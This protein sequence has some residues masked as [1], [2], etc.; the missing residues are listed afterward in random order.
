MLASPTRLRFV[1]QFC[2][3]LA[4][5]AVQVGAGASSKRLICVHA[6]H[7]AIL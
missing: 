1:R 5:E 7:P 6:K 2:K 3:I 4:E